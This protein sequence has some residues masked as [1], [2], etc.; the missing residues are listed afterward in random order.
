MAKSSQAKPQA[1]NAV[2]VAVANA[3]AT[4]EAVAGAE[5]FA[6]YCDHFTGLE[7][8]VK[9]LGKV[10]SACADKA[11]V[12]EL[13]Q[14]WV[15]YTVASRGIL[16]ASAK[17]RLRKLS[18]QLAEFG[19][20]LPTKN[21]VQSV[22]AKDTADRRAKAKANKSPEARAAQEALD[23][24]EAAEKAAAA[25]QKAKVKEAR[26]QICDL[27]NKTDDLDTLEGWFLHL[28]DSAE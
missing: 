26:K 12:W 22:K 4:V 28:T 21:P 2:G 17:D 1:Q 23:A 11:E 9:A 15:A 5:V 14:K 27:V 19:V 16:E 8:D 7:A 25:E 18:K 20:T 13:T 6:Q 10:V 24:I 3:V